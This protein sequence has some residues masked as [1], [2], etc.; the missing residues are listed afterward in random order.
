MLIMILRE[1]NFMQILNHCTHINM[2]FKQKGKSISLHR[3]K[4]GS[5]KCAMSF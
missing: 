2:L 1:S 5:L 3:V 4:S